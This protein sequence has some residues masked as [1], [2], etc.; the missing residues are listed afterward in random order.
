M[1]LVSNWPHGYSINKFEIDKPPHSNFK[2]KKKTPLSIKLIQRQTTTKIRSLT[3]GN[4][5]K[6]FLK[7]PYDSLHSSRCCTLLSFNRIKCPIWLF[8]LNPTKTS[9]TMVPKC[10]IIDE[11]LVTQNCYN[12]FRHSRATIPTMSWQNRPTLKCPRIDEHI[13]AP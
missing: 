3:H 1:N 6:Y 12:N 13:H 9:V 5:C 8:F 10:H 7:P 4:K 11:L 2:K